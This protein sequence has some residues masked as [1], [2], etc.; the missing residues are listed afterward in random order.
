MGEQLFAIAYK[1]KLPAGTSKAGKEKFKTERGYRAPISTDD[2]SSLLTLAL[3]DKVSEWEARNILPNEPIDD[4]SNYDRGHRLYGMY[5]WLDV[6]SQ[7]QAFGHCV[8]VEVFHDLVDELRQANDGELKDLDKAALSYIAIAM[9]KALNYNSR[10]S[11]WMPTREIMANTFNRHNFAFQWSHAEMAPTSLGV[12]YDW[13]IEQTGTAIKELIDLTSKG[14]D[15][16]SLFEQSKSR[17]TIQITRGSADTLSL[18]DASVDCVVMDPPYYDNVMYAEL[19]DFFYVWLKR[20]IGLIYPETFSDYL[21]DKDREAV[22]NLA[23]FKGQKFGAKLL[24]NRDYQERMA[25]I[26]SECRRVIKP[27]GVLT[28]M[29]THKASG[30]WDALATGLVNAGFVITASWPVNTES[31]ASLHIREKSAAKSTIFLVCRPREKQL[32]N[33]EIVYWENVEP[34][35]QE[36]V[37]ERVAEFQEAGIGGVDLY[38]ASFG[39]ALQVFSENWPLRRGRPVQKPRELALFPDEDFDPYA[40]WP[41]DAL[42]AARREVKRWRMEQLATVKRQH[43]LDPLTEW[44]I[45]A[46]DAFK[47]PRFPV[48]EALKLARVVG[49]DFDQEI[50]NVVGEVKSSD[51]VL[52]DSSVRKA[53]GK[54]GP[55]GD[56]CMLN[57]LHQAA[58]IV[59]E[60]NTGA[61]KKA[62]EDNGLLDD[63][64][65]LTTLEALLNV[66]PA[67]ASPEKAPKLEAHLAAAS[68]DFAA[69][70]KLRRLAFSEI[71]PERVVQMEMQFRG[72]PRGTV[73]LQENGSSESVDLGLDVTSG[74]D[75]ID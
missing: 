69:L 41:E 4:L 49:L 39:P 16:P 8:G 74:D 57:T 71:V 19:S 51:M 47:A 24:A 60:K 46:W 45:L 36:A 34:L 11:I 28:V 3:V 38:L 15:E 65:L 42:D 64:T 25:A 68:S 7:R 62:I 27:D 70:E 48:D 63:A 53:K 13:T 17:G 31:E 6:F 55:M 29:F 72:E 44:Y 50:K 37:R 22:A 32:E 59:R 58:S 66:L 1:R 73:N 52:W 43:H 21:T 61:S 75:D 14:D 54:L 26:F 2:V 23:K 40:V 30:A 56:T 67:V 18:P 35:V 5:K 20:T 10:M 33:A 12:G 9:D